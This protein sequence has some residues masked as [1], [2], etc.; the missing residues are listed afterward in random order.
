[1]PI[2]V[3]CACGK[4]LKVGEQFVG[5][6]VRCPSCNLPV[7]VPR[8]QPPV[9]TAVPVIRPILP[10]DQ[11]AAP[12]AEPVPLPPLPSALQRLSFA[13]DEPPVS[14]PELPVA[15]PVAPP[16]PS[17]EPI[18]VECGCGRD[19]LAGA[20]L[21][22]KLVRCPECGQA[23]RVPNPDEVH[24][25]EHIEVLEEEEKSIF[26][27]NPED[28]LLE[29]KRGTP[30]AVETSFRGMMGEMELDEVA[31]CLA[32][33]AGGVWALA[34]QS[35]YIQV[36]DM[37]DFTRKYRFKEHEAVVTSLA[38]SLDAAYA[39]SGDDGG[40]LIYWDIVHNRAI[41]RFKGHQGP[42]NAIAF[43][44]GGKYAASGGEDGCLRLWE[45]A[46]GTEYELENASWDG[47]V[48]A[49]AYSNDGKSILAG[50]E[51]GR[52]AVWSIQ[53]GKRLHKLKG[54]SGDIDT[55][56]FAQQGHLA[57]AGALR[58]SGLGIQAWQWET[59]GGQ[60]IPS[61]TNPSERLSDPHYVCLS[62]NGQRLLV[63]SQKHLNRSKWAVNDMPAGGSITSALGIGGTMHGGHNLELWTLDSG[64][65]AYAFEE[66]IGKIVCLAVNPENTRVLA[67]LKTALVVTFGLPL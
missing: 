3:I 9:V 58:K 35:E 57:C 15:A 11:S 21:A 23:V 8:F 37:K 28:A 6:L 65:R 66:V 13:L 51:G 61:F 48:L 44:P 22:G 4:H 41:R 5:S 12:T 29:G 40:R 47:A 42:V 64:H 25:V 17:G 39:L 59:I 55:V 7:E 14:E 49:L 36:L 20:N 26:A 52:V 34:S 43:S 32:Y 46:E 18:E 24:E 30:G 62:S 31:G 67:G 63:G 45:L 1:M 33:S 56:A 54:A 10:A 19:F 38:I 27:L 16:P 2:D 60:S 53:T 50:G